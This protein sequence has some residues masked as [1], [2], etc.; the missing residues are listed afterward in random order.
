MPR[1]PK[2]SIPPAV[3]WE[4]WRRDGFA[5]HYCGSTDGAATI[6]HKIP[7]SKGGLAVPDN[8]V[9]ACPKCNA[10]KGTKSYKTFLA[11][12]AMVALWKISA[13]GDLRRYF[14]PCYQLSASEAVQAIRSESGQQREIYY[15]FH[16]KK[17]GKKLDRMLG[18]MD[19]PA[20]AG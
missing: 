7:E 2:E 8:L 5:C 11:E 12:R 4:V 14:K 18:F 13:Q 9:T 19:Y 6:D 1:T 16:R 10:R 17:H 15:E 3:R 20:E